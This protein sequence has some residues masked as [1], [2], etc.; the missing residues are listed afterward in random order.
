MPSEEPGGMTLELNRLNPLL[1]CGWNDLN[2]S[3]G[4]L[5]SPRYALGDNREE[6]GPEPVVD[7]QGF[8]DGVPGASKC[9]YP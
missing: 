9:L 7:P 8:E 3:P 4:A 2:L 6:S 1:L 5:P